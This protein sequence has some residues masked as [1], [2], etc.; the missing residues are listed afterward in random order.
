[1]PENKAIEP[2]ELSIKQKKFL[3]KL[4]HPLSVSVQI[5]KEGVSDGLLESLRAALLHHE[6]IKVKISNNSGLEKKK[7][8]EDIPRKTKSSLVQLIGKTLILYKENPKRKKE[9]RIVLPKL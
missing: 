5:G 6:L 1:M 4:A 9:K 8:A 7:A 2:P 3:R